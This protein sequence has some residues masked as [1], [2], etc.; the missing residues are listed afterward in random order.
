M[1]QTNQI[2]PWQEGVLSDWRIRAINHYKY[3]VRKFL[4]VAMTKGSKCITVEGPDDI[5]LWRELYRKAK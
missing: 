2:L 3:G 4:Y 1:V 5:E